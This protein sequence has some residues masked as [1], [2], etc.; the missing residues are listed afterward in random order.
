[1]QAIQDGPGP[2]RPSL[3]ASIFSVSHLTCVPATGEGRVAGLA[4][5]VLT[6]LL[7]GVCLAGPFFSLTPLA[8][9]ARGPLTGP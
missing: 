7:L 8:P 3:G 9:S 4:L 2:G 6:G 5:G 1:M